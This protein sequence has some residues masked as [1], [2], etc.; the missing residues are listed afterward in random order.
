[1]PFEACPVGDTNPICTGNNN[2]DGLEVYRS[3]FTQEG[4]DCSYTGTTQ[5]GEQECNGAQ[6]P[7]EALTGGDSLGG[8]TEQGGDQG[9]LIIG[10]DHDTVKTA[11]QTTGAC[12]GKTKVTKTA[13]RNFG[14][15]AT[16]AV[17]TGGFPAAL[18]GLTVQINGTGYVV[19]SCATPSA[20]ILYVNG[21]LG[22]QTNLPFAAYIAP[23]ACGTNGCAN[24]VIGK[25]Q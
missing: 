11:N 20:S 4:K 9:G 21:S 3:H 12:A 7:T 24:G 18:E 13:G 22:T 14:F 5:A 16:S 6:T 19:S 25:K 23:T 8:S 2:F 17:H 10:W 15:S 1:M